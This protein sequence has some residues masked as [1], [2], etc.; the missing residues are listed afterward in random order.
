MKTEVVDVSPTRKE[1]KI[2]IGAEE[3]RAEFDRVAEE[4]ARAVNVPGFRKG[5]VPR[6]LVNGNTRV[7]TSE[8]D[9]LI[10]AVGGMEHHLAAHLSVGAEGQLFYISYGNP[11]I[12]PAPGTAV[13]RTKTAMGT[14]LLVM[15]RFYL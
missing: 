15:A 8:T 13:T 14:A 3:V 11:A 1:I 5:H 7:D 6:S 9:Y 12:S 4:Y 2:E 10:G